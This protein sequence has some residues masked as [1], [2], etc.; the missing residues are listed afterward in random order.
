MRASRRLRLRASHADALVED[1]TAERCQPS[2]LPFP[3]RP[4][5]DSR[6]GSDASVGGVGLIRSIQRGR[7][8]GLDRRG[9]GEKLKGSSNVELWHMESAGAVGA[10]GLRS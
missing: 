8:H 3:L 7:T 5:L 6:E 4:E 10:F 2:R 1:R 9:T